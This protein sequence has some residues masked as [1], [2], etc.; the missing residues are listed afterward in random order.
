MAKK[1]RKSKSNVKLFLALGGIAV[2]GYF[3]LRSQIRL[4]SFGGVSIPFQQL[5][6]G[7]INLGLRLPILNASALSA[8]VTGFTGFIVAPSG[9]TVGSVFLAEPATVAAFQQN[10]L[11]FNASIRLSDIA[12]E[13][14]G[15]VL[16]GSLPASWGN[17][18]E[19][20]KGYKLIGQLRV[21]GLPLP[22]ETPLL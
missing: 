2:A 22:V 14:G 3:W 6:D 5:K 18:I 15:M 10:E 13:A 16:G 8:R 19:Y 20:L 4:I 9:S 7:K 12:T 1:G 11:K 17:A 21:F